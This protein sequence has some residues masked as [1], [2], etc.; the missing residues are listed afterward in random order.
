MLP[1]PDHPTRVG[2]MSRQ[3]VIG[4]GLA[5]ML[6]QHPARVVLAPTSDAEVVLYDVLGLH[7]ADDRDLDELLRQANTA[8]LALSQDLHPELRARAMA[9]GARAWISI[10][11]AAEQIIDAVEAVATGQ[12]LADQVDTLGRDVGLT[13]REVEV[14]S[15]VAQGHSNLQIA[16]RLYLSINS[17]KT[18]I[19]SAYAK[20]G[21]T[22]RTRAVAWCLLHGFAPPEG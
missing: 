6:A 10:S 20:I 18:Y 7:V 17:V 1:V 21:V 11:S 13:A 2:I 19:R 8:V 12:P 9:K 14:L 4:K 3:E 22:S 15:L 16:E 5:A